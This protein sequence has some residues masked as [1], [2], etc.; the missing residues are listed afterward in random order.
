M[1]DKT[2]SLDRLEQVREVMRDWE[3]FPMPRD[4]DFARKY[5]GE[6]VA[7]YRGQ[8]VAHGRN[9]AEVAQAATVQKYPGATVFY[10]PTREQQEGVWILG[11]T[12][13]GG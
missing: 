3:T 7:V 1:A 11:M 6:W 8:V 13:L 5:A 9:G 12:S 10:V 2:K 4:P